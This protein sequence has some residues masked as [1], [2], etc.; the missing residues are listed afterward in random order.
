MQG[1]ESRGTFAFE[2]NVIP[3]IDILLVLLIIFM[4]MNLGERRVIEL[5]LPQEAVPAEPSEPQIVLEVSPGGVYAINQDAVS[6]AELRNRLQVIYNGRPTKILFVKGDPR[7]RYQEVIEAIDLA[8]GAGV[9]A[10]GVAP[11]DTPRSL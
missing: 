10:I 2:P 9:V 8:R 5:Q 11:K 7:A 6:A 4:L 3:M 1:G